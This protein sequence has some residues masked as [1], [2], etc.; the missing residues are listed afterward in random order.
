MGP[1]NICWFDEGRRSFKIKKNP[2]MGKKFHFD[3]GP[4]SSNSGK[5]LNNSSIGQIYNLIFSYRDYPSH[6]C[7]EEIFTGI[8]KIGGV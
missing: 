1:A 8:V 7:R 6:D 2:K 3:S 5:N 4:L